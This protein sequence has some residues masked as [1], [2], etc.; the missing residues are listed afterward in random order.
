MPQMTKE[1]INSL[2]SA[3]AHIPTDEI[4]RDIRD[5]EAEIERMEKEITALRTLGDKMSHFRAD[6]KRNGIREREAFIEKLKIIL[7][8]REPEIQI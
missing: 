5:T 7:A 4:E 6:G 2:I 8:H 1:E 3:N